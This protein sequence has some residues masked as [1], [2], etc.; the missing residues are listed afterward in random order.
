MSD[1]NG[2]KIWRP[3]AFSVIGFLFMGLVG[4][5]SVIHGQTEKY[6]MLIST[7]GERLSIVEA[8]LLMIDVTLSR[9]EKK[10]DDITQAFLKRTTGP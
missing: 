6:E 10:L 2:S 3:V 1:T 8:R 7:R 5:M 4:W 9:I